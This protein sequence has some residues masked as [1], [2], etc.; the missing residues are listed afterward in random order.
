MECHHYCYKKRNKRK[1][2]Q[3]VTAVSYCYVSPLAHIFACTWPPRHPISIHLQRTQG[4]RARSPRSR[5]V[6]FIDLV[7]GLAHVKF[8]VCHQAEVTDLHIGV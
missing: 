3:Q 2:A 7:Y 4:D 6:L 5:G 8:F 1:L